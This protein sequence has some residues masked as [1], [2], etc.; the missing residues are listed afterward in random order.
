MNTYWYRWSSSFEDEAE[1]CF[2]VKLHRSSHHGIVNHVG[3]TSFLPTIPWPILF[4]PRD[5]WAWRGWQYFTSKGSM[6]LCFCWEASNL[7]HVV[8]NHTLNHSFLGAT[9][10]S[11][12][13]QVQKSPSA[14]ALFLF[15]L[16]FS[17]I[18]MHRMHHFQ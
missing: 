15:L 3:S 10:C 4:F 13:W 7:A 5:P 12:L 16:T 18:L 8:R 11:K 17:L 1:C 2:V 9:K 14:L 6:M